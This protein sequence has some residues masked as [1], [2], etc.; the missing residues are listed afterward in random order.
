L[1]GN[2]VAGAALLLNVSSHN[3]FCRISLIG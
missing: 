2:D 3:R 1:H